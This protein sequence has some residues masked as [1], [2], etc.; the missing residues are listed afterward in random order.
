MEQPMNIGAAATASCVTA[1]M[2]RYYEKIRLIEPAERTASGYRLYGMNDVHTL[3]FIRRARDLGFSVADIQQL[4]ALWRNRRR[5]SADVKAVAN[6][7]LEALQTK[8]TE[9]QGMIDALETLV[10]ACTDDQRPDCPILG[11]LAEEEKPTPAMMV[12]HR[13]GVDRLV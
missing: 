6:Q 12:G 2:I 10:S 3:R 5:A 7:H 4:L 9:M 11:D 8:V 1:K 13:F